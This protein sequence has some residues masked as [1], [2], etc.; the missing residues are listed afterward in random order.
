MNSKRVIGA[1]TLFT[2]LFF[3]L[4]VTSNAVA[5]SDSRFV[6]STDK[7]N[8]GE[9][10][11]DAFME[12]QG[13]KKLPSKHAGN[14]GIDRVYV[15]YGKN[16]RIEKI[17]LVESK[18]D[19]SQYNKNQMSDA[20]IREQIQKMKVSKDPEVRKIGELLEKYFDKITKELHHHNSKTGK[21]TIS[22][23]NKDGSVGKV[24]AEVNMKRAIRKLLAGQTNQAKADLNKLSSPGADSKAAMS[25]ESMIASTVKR[26]HDV[27]RKATE[28]GQKT[29]ASANGKIGPVSGWPVLKT[30]AK[31]AVPAQIGILGYEGA[32]VGYQI[33]ENEVV[34]T[35]DL[36]K[37]SASTLGGFAAAYPGAAGGAAVGTMVCPGPCTIIGG[38][39]G[40]MVTGFGGVFLSEMAFDVV[41]SSAVKADLH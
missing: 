20:T 15:K 14:Q 1:Y 19:S 32:K 5:F 25:N 39:V 10:V 13:Y 41:Y 33:A 30:V 35:R 16:G 17:L 40:G 26:T 4:F 9:S 37:A 3:A 8:F 11:S 7:G 6:N 22:E 12:K 31:L 28:S 34:D 36:G 38:V 18:V 23:L 2:V 21:T 24:K 27:L 29:L